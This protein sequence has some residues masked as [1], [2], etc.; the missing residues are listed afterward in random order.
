MGTGTGDHENPLKTQHVTG[1]DAPADGPEALVQIDRLAALGTLVASVAH[2]INNPVTYVLGNLEELQRIA[3]AMRDALGSCRN[4]LERSLDGAAVRSIDAKLE[5]AGGIEHLDELVGDA[6]D[7]A[8]RIRTL[9]RDLLALS[10]GGS[11]QTAATDVNE[12]LRSAIRLAARPLSAAA[13][14]ET[15]YRATREVEADPAR[16]GQV[17]L[18]LLTNAIDACQPLDPERHV[19]SVRTLD[20][21]RGVRVEIADTGTGISEEIRSQ[22]F[23]PLFTTKEPSRGT[24]LGLYISRRIVE[25]HG[26]SIEAVPARGGGTLL[27]VSLPCRQPRDDASVNPPLAR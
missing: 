12:V 1:G 20:T 26:G 18:N 23:R 8:Q 6:L 7:G 3:F 10:Y 19:V 4:A 25:E 17:F 14:L 24:G 22:I 13:R 21:D 27:S 2:E 5:A 16:L 15:S 9:V 11:P